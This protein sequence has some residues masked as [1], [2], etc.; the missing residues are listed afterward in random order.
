VVGDLEAMLLLQV[1]Q[2][3]QE[4][5]EM[6]HLLEELH[7]QQAVVVKYQIVFQVMGDLVEE[8]LIQ[9]FQQD[10]ET[11]LLLLQHKEQMVLLVHQEEVD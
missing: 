8:H 7:Q 4:Q 11:H 2:V 6:F 5:Q 9:V 1:I 3:E 10:Q